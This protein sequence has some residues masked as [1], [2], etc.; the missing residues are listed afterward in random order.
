RQMDPNFQRQLADKDAAVRACK[1]HNGLTPQEPNT[2]TGAAP[3]APAA[4]TCHAPTGE[5]YFYWAIA[6]HETNAYRGSTPLTNNNWCNGINGYCGATSGNPASGQPRV[7]TPF[8]VASYGST[9]W[10]VESYMGHLSKWSSWL[11][12]GKEECVPYCLRDVLQD[13]GM[14]TRI[15]AAKKRK[16]FVT[17]YVYKGSTCKKT[18]CYRSITNGDISANPWLNKDADYQA[19]MKDEALRANG[20]DNMAESRALLKRADQWRWLTWQ[21]Q[22][23]N[24]NPENDTGEDAYKKLFKPTMEG[25]RVAEGLGM[26]VDEYRDPSAPAYSVNQY[27]Y[28]PPKHKRKGPIWAE[29]RNHFASAAIFAPDPVL[30]EKSMVFFASGDCFKY[31]SLQKAN[32]HA[33]GYNAKNDDDTAWVYKAAKAWNGTGS[34]AEKYAGEIVHSYQRLRQNKELQK[35]TVCNRNDQSHDC[36]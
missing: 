19:T 24:A 36:H 20:F 7:G 29:A 31:A 27:F 2:F 15:D 35:A 30:R 32:I 3:T 9:Q 10:T 1:A 22:K 34:P 11:A 4:S 14:Q 13:P 18:A 5:D 33:F 21:M 23:E 6:K 16:I 28:Y 25:R 26:V 12:Q 8:Y 17:N